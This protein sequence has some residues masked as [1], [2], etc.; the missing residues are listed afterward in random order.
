MKMKENQGVTG[1]LSNIEL[2][3]LVQMV[4]LGGADLCV[5]AL[6][7]DR[8]G[9]IYI[10]AGNIVH[11]ETVNNQGEDALFEIAS[12]EDIHFELKSNI[13]AD[14][15]TINKPWEFLMLEATRLRDE[16]K[17]RQKINVLVVDDSVFFA[18]R[19]RELIEEDEKFHVVGIASNGSEALG[20]LE[21]E[22]IDVI[23]M[24]ILM[25]VMSGDTAI[26][27]VMLKYKIPVM[28]I[29]AFAGETPSKIFEFL[30][31]GVVEIYPKQSGEEL[32]NSYGQELRN[33]IKK[34]L[35]ARVDRFRVLRK[36]N[37]KPVSDTVSKSRVVIIAGSEGSYSEW[38]RLPPDVFAS[39]FVFGFTTLHPELLPDFSKL[40]GEY[41]GK[42]VVC[43]NQEYK[44]KAKQKA[45]HIFSDEYTWKLISDEFLLETSSRKK[46][47]FTDKVLMFVESVMQESN[48]PVDVLL[49]SSTE[50]ASSKWK[51]ILSNSRVNIWVPDPDLLLCPNLAESVIE[52]GNKLPGSRVILCSLWHQIGQV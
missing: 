33:K 38:F 51:N 41:S 10:K 32:G 1:K 34:I 25:P 36:A 30:R 47:N 35:G 12:W 43:L 17:K 37:W 4:C 16:A 45:I 13:S 40:V 44:G 27:H 8:E 15:Q 26:K 50:R 9:K 42:D 46:S 20:F 19:L 29:S 6:S 11:A 52:M 23:I 31:L 48:F 14:R 3:Q 2:S 39:S 24:D 22:Q 28:I 5:I 18:K 7:D 49:L 21:S